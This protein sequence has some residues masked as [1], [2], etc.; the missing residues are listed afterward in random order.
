ML[1]SQYRKRYFAFVV[2]SL[3]VHL[4]IIVYL[5]WNPI[6][7]EKPKPE[8]TTVEIKLK[9]KP[10]P[11]KKKVEEKKQAPEEKKTDKEKSKEHKKAEPK[12]KEP[13][14]KKPTKEE[15]KKTEPK[16]AEPKKRDPLEEQFS[17]DKSKD[18]KPRKAQ[19]KKAEPKK[20]EPKKAEP[21]KV[22]PRKAQP[23]KAEP[24]KA[25]PRKVEPKKAETRKDPPKS[26]R[27]KDKPSTE[28]QP[29]DLAYWTK[30]LGSEQ[31]LTDRDLQRTIIYS[32]GENI[33]LDKRSQR[34]LRALRYL[35]PVQR[36]EHDSYY[37]TGANTIY[38]NFISPKKIE[39][40]FH[41]EIRFVMD[42]EGY[43]SEMNLKTPSG[44]DALDQA[45][46]DAVRRTVRLELPK[47]PQAAFVFI[48]LP[49]LFY[50][51]E[52]DLAE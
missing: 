50:Y 49:K 2:V 46:L 52:T 24:K 10:E 4:A 21:R 19:P 9:K 7:V 41:G 32:E 13:K 11:E 45:M 16:K 37:E 5:L 43:I 34:G 25:E 36:Q 23:K 47:N 18:Q 42:E 39:G 8:K 28:P 15:P 1:P 27:T 51:D 26:D 14:K 20:A 38:A 22:E 48:E 40:K 6:S 44:Y 3:L 31:H 30:K 33:S 35:S 17:V 12:K 29:T